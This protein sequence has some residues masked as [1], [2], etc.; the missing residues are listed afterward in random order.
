MSKQENLRGKNLGLSISLMG[1]K[2]HA[3]WF[4]QH[5]VYEELICKY[6]LLVLNVF[7]ISLYSE[8]P[9]NIYTRTE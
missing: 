9:S 5:F 1:D 6:N 8:Y 2:H 7:C 3:W 4:K